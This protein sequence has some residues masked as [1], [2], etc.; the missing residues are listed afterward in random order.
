MPPERTLR[1]APRV[2]VFTADHCGH[3][4]RAK[5]FLRE[6]GIAFRE[7]NVQ[8]SRKARQQFLRL[9]ARGVPVILVGEKRLHGFH[10]ATLRKLLKRAGC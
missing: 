1:D 7:L 10:A 4:Q 9:N 6:Q 8:R 2:T 3:C 5:T